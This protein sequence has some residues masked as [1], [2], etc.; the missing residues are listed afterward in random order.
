MKIVIQRMSISLSFQFSL[1]P[2]PVD[3]QQRSSKPNDYSKI[4]VLDID[5]GS[6]D[7]PAMI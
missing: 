1:V 4:C 5:C 7:A 2:V 6:A 3:A